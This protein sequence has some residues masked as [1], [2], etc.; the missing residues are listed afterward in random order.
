M[1]LEDRG[2]QHDKEVVDKYHAPN[3][4]YQMSTLD[5]V[6]R[7]S[8]DGISGPIVITL[9]PVAEALGRFYSF[10]ARKADNV[11]DI[12][13]TDANDSECWVA[14]IVLN[15]KCDRTLLY[16]DGLCWQPM[17]GGPGKWPGVP[18]TGAPGTTNAP[19]TL[20]PTVVPTT[21]P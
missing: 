19:T 9:P 20:E 1:A 16:S 8:A 10:V 7:P 17:G 21:N 15:G 4:A 12:T 5:Y 2:A 14:D 6:M 18:G 11:N 3:D 13:I